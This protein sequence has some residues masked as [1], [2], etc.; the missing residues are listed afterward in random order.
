MLALL[1]HCVGFT[2]VLY[3]MNL[4]WY[5]SQ[6]GLGDLSRSIQSVAPFMECTLHWNVLTG[7]TCIILTKA[8]VLFGLGMVLM[9]AAIAWA[10]A[11][12]PWLLGGMVLLVSLLF[13]LLVPDYSVMNPAKY[14]NF[15]GLM[16]TD[17][18]Y[19]NYLNF[20]I[21]GYP[22]SRL[23]AALTALGIYILA[24]IGA[25]LGLFLSFRTP[26]LKT[27]GLLSGIQRKLPFQRFLQ[28]HPHASLYRHESYKILIMNRAL[29]VLLLF[30]L[31]SAWQHLSAHYSLSPYETYY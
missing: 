14:L 31:F 25:N 30:C 19:G 12:M 10:Q 8:A 23:L 28:F 20:N 17:I 21:L 5:G 26:E 18:L 16:Q 9:A 1:I 4:L 29:A 2:V 27:G 7:I 13:Y 3:G 6:A 22:I 11:F 24:A 15:V